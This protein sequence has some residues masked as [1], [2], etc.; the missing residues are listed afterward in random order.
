M[1]I[2]HGLGEGVLSVSGQSA[3]I[4]DKEIYSVLLGGQPR[5]M[6][7][8]G[9]R[10]TYEYPMADRFSIVGYYEKTTQRSNISLFGIDNEGFYLGVKYR[11]GF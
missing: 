6:S 4:D 11:G 7:R 8:L 2:S 1:G 3:R 10:V 9:G 5:T